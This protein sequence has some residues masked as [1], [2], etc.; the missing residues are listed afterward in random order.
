MSDVFF[1]FLCTGQTENNDNN[2]HNRHR[3]ILRRRCSCW[4]MTHDA[5]AHLI[6][7]S[8]IQHINKP[9]LVSK[10]NSF[11]TFFDFFSRNFKMRGYGNQD[12]RHDNDEQV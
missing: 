5:T 10:L 9:R 11:Q 8:D 4:T 2:T 3:Y 7:F 12:D 6:R 1:D